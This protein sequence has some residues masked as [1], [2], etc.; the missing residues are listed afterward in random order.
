MRKFCLAAVAI[1]WLSTT[2]AAAEKPLEWSGLI[3]ETAVAKLPD[4]MTTMKPGKFAFAVIKDEK[5][6]RAFVEAAGMPGK[7]DWG[8]DWDKQ[9]LAVVV[10]QENTNRLKFKDMSARDKGLVLSF[11]WDLIEPLYKGR[12]PAVMASFDPVMG[13]VDK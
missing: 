10:L 5:T 6:F 4:V 12:N 3:D 13:G 8:I 7:V 2:A 9:A 1:G 11:Q